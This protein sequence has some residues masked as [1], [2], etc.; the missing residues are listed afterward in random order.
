MAVACWEAAGA[1]DC[2][3]AVACLPCADWAYVAAAPSPA[4]ADWACVAAAP[5]PACAGS[6]EA[7]AP[8]PACA[9]C[10]VESCE[11]APACVG[12]DDAAALAAGS[13]KGV[14]CALDDV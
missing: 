1:S 13:S 14:V 4:C 8:S 3:I 10:S 9:G 11:A 12:P 7:P 5:S 6:C 2:P